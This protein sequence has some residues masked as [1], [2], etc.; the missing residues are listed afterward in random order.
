MFGFL[1]VDKPIG[2]TSRDVVNV[3]QRTLKPLK[4][5]HAGTLDPLATGVLVVAVGGATRLIDLVQHQAKT[6]IATFRFGVRS[7]TDDLEGELVA[8]PGELPS[9]AQIE[10]ALPEFV[11]NISQIPPAYSAIKIK[12]ERAYHLAR[13]GQE[14]ELAARIV[15]IDDLSID[16]YQAPDLTL[17]VKCGA[18]TYIRSLGRDLGERLGTAAVMTSLR[19]EAIGGFQAQQAVTWEWLLTADRQ[20]LQS[21]LLG[22][23]E[24]L[25]NVPVIELSVED[26][27]ALRLGK[28]VQ[29]SALTS[30]SSA[31]ALGRD[32]WRRAH[33]LLQATDAGWRID[34]AFCADE[35]IL[36]QP[37]T[38][39]MQTPS[40]PIKSESNWHQERQHL[41]AELHDGFV[42]EVIGAKMLI[43]SLDEG[44][45]V[46][47][48][49]LSSTLTKV[50]AL[51]GQAA[52]EA[53]ELIRRLDQPTESAVDSGDEEFPSANV[54]PQLVLQDVRRRLETWRSRLAQEWPETSVEWRLDEL[55]L[56]VEFAWDVWR[57]IQ[58]GT[59]NAL[60]HGQASVLSVKLIHDKSQAVW[61]L[62][63]CDNG[64]GFDPSADSGRFGLKGMRVR[65]SRHGGTLNVNSVPNQGTEIV[66]LWPAK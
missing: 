2:R 49:R 16:N 55:P 23:F 33:A 57:I 38:T 36:N 32:P 18:G 4:V 3:V 58:E 27:H 42:Q 61:R 52:Q 5:G 40:P 51:L 12:G 29:P 15:R 11:G 20:A 21:R 60:V 34:K 62:S 6:Y 26:C 54:D 14:V 63:I 47:K 31:V 56:P 44:Q 50:S 66:A 8:V 35:P 41:A 24:A 43:D 64:R 37:P 39:P 30:N 59:R 13:S 22:P 17:T 53:R 28:A 48:E 19:R 46:E 25:P 9:R 1:N 7:N 10:A 65:T 45:S